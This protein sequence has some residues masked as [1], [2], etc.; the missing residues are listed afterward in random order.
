[1]RIEIEGDR[2]SP[3]YRTPVP[4][5]R[6]RTAARA[7]RAGSGQR[8]QPRLSPAAARADPPRNGIVLVVAP[9]DVRASPPTLEP[10]S[11]RRLA[12]AVYAEMARA[13]I[14]VVGEFHYLHHRADGTPYEDP[15]AM[16]RALV[17]A[18]AAA[19]VRLTLLDACYLHGGIGTPPDE[20]PASIQRRRRRQRG[21]AGDGAGRSADRRPTVRV[22]AAIHSVRAVDPD[23]HATVVAVGGRARCAVA[24]PRLRAAGRERAVSGRLRRHARRSAGRTGAL[25]R[26]VHRRARHP[27]DRRRHRLLGV[28]GAGAAPARPPSASWPT[29]SGPSGALADAGVGLCVGSDSHAVIDLLEEARGIELH[30]RLATGQRGRFAPEALLPAATEAGIGAWAGPR[31]AA[32]PGRVGRLRD[33]RRPQSSARPGSAIDPLGIGGVRG[34]RRRHHRR[35][36]RRRGV[37]E[38]GR[39][40]R[41]T[42]RPPWPTSSERR[43]PGRPSLELGRRCAPTLGWARR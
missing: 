15:N 8:P 5:R 4:R 22:G 9:A 43:T 7:H 27:P 25:E 31:A 34:R 18:A 21:P 24:R 28:A 40:V 32:G 10:D 20:T 14:T 12:T 36:R 17:D 13:G 30:E 6:R 16:G 38:R 11:Y 26:P 35:R 37:V 3:S 19:G 2:S 29:A 33:D 23:A 41:S 42:S 39:H 1:M